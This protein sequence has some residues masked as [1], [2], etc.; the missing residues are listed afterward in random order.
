MNNFIIFS[1]AYE[2]TA[3]SQQVLQC[4][5]MFSELEKMAFSES[6]GLDLVGNYPVTGYLG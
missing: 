4:L 1:V 3:N 6:D 2:K 5:S